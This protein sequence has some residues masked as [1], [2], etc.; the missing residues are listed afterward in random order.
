MKLVPVATQPRSLLATRLPLLKTRTMG[1]VTATAATATTTTTSAKEDTINHEVTQQ[2][3]GQE[4]RRR[5]NADSI[6]CSTM[7]H[8]VV[9]RCWKMLENARRIGSKPIAGGSMQ[10]CTRVQFW[11]LARG[12]D[13]LRWCH[14]TRRLII[15]IQI[16]I[17]QV[18]DIARPT[19][20]SSQVKSK[21]FQAVQGG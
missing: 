3:K 15:L 7:M 14:G 2:Q 17:L 13:L 6:E 18:Q 1:T 8:N 11:R 21:L 16:E 9:T 19:H 20:R 5:K 10:E 4:P 12:E